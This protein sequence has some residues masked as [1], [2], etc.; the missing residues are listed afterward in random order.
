MNLS[1]IPAQIGISVLYGHRI[2][3]EIPSEP[4]PYAQTTITPD[5]LDQF[6]T[7]HKDWQALSIDDLIHKN[8]DPYKP[9]F[10]LTFDDG[11]RDMLVPLVGILEKHNVPAAIFICHDYCYHD[12]EPLEQDFASRLGPDQ[13]HLYDQYR[14]KLKKGSL[15]K[16]QKFLQWLAIEYGLPPKGQKTHFLSPDDIVVLDNHPLVTLGHHSQSHPLLNRLGVCTLWRELASPY[17]SISYPYGGHNALVRCIA[18]LRGH[19]IGFTTNPRLFKPTQ[20]PMMAIP[21]IELKL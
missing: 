1:D 13:H 6:L 15:S 3:N 7:D 19:K 16:R 2:S 4:S 12:L 21:R 5:A 20:H 14:H 10:A 8:F 18:R 11:Y 17:K 9:A